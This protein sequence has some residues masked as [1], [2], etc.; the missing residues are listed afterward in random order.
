M[1]VA[2]DSLKHTV[3][4]NTIKTMPKAVFFSGGKVVFYGA[5][6]FLADDLFL[7]IESKRKTRFSLRQIEY[8][9]SNSGKVAESCQMLGMGYKQ[10]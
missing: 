6:V 2:N 7:V 4:S 3:W 5:Y 9:M 8:L 10:I 1:T